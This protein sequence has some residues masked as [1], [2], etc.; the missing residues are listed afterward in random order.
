MDTA[1]RIIF[2]SSSD[3]AFPC[4]D[5]LQ[6]NPLVHLCGVLTQPSRAKGRGQVVT[7]NVVGQ[8]AQQHSI[9]FYPA[10]QIDEATLQWV[11]DLSPDI[12]LVMAFG[13]ILPQRFLSIPSLGTWNLHV[14]LLPKYRGASPIQSALLNGDRETGVTFMRLVP[15][16]DAGPYLLQETV[17]IEPQDTSITLGEKLA[18]KSAEVL[19]KA[20]P[21]LNLSVDCTPQVDSQATFCK[22]I[23]KI[24]GVLDFNQPAAALERQV[25]AFQP[26]PGSYFFKEGIRYKVLQ[27]HLADATTHCPPGTFIVNTQ[28][29]TLTIA[30]A[31]G[32]LAI[33]KIQKACERPM[34]IVDFLRGHPQF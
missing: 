6:N 34:P 16:L 10:D 33:D 3:I 7:L 11:N 15:K 31:D 19:A 27:A 22:K 2:C 18:Y 12:I 13:H 28:R 20:L 29:T 21:M 1:P 17:L 14:S 32:Y 24:D 30:T 23:S 9:P 8:W 5:Y 26:W 4:L 25:R